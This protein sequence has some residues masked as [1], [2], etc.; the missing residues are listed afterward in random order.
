MNND[1]HTRTYQGVA[2]LLTSILIAA[3]L[4]GCAGPSARST[5]N[6]GPWPAEAENTKAFG[7]Y[8]SALVLPGDPPL[9]FAGGEVL[10]LGKGG[11]ELEGSFSGEFA[12]G[13][14][15]AGVSGEPRLDGPQMLG[16]RVVFTRRASESVSDT[17]GVTQTRE[18]GELVLIDPRD[19]SQ[20]EVVCQVEG[21]IDSVQA[22][23]SEETSTQAIAFEWSPSDVQERVVSVVTREP[24]GSWTERWSTDVREQ[25]D[26]F[27]ALGYGFVASGGGSDPSVIVVGDA[28]GAVRVLK[29]RLGGDEQ[30]ITGE[31]TGL[32]EPERVDYLGTYRVA[33]AREVAFRVRAMDGREG[34]LLSESA[35]ESARVRWLDSGTPLLV[36]DDDRGG[37]A[38]LVGPTAG[39]G[40]LE[41]VSLDG[42]GVTTI[43]EDSDVAWAG[44]LSRVDGAP[45]R[46]ALV[47][48]TP[49]ANGSVNWSVS[50]LAYDELGTAPEVVSLMDAWHTPNQNWYVTSVDDL[51]AAADASANLVVI[52]LRGETEGAVATVRAPEGP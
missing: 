26:G 22:Y 18:I 43:A 47:G 21:L 41:L 5:D 45:R 50:Q 34:V 28:G 48:R 44:W 31:S 7:G 24:D 39:S 3:L 15:Q 37:V 25:D 51:P 38:A 12:I 32:A 29:V 30:D 8:V 42:A 4:A 19:P 6:A 33:G 11:F 49:E 23:E 16:S 46:V 52:G 1:S 17:Q 36:L 27:M 2:L 10:S 14:E 13:S 35:G 20:R 40:P 9:V